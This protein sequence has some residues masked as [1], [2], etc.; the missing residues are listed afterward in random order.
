[1]AFWLSYCHRSD[2]D[3]SLART[4]RGIRENVVAMQVVSGNETTE[5]SLVHDVKVYKSDVEMDKEQDRQLVSRMDS[6]KTASDPLKEEVETLR[7]MKGPKGGQGD[8]GPKGERGGRGPKGESG[9]AEPQGESGSA[10]PQGE[11]GSA[12][13]QGES[14]SAGPQGERGY[15]G[16]RGPQKSQHVMEVLALGGEEAERSFL[17]YHEDE[18]NV[19]GEDGQAVAGGRRSAKPAQR[20]ERSACSRPS[21]LHNRF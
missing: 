13:P 15:R 17:V 16:D 21:W 11:S 10:G 2:A 5:N 1:M 12:G 19:D 14:G 18:V 3:D 6:A 7:K 4:L 9:L 20:G 8:R